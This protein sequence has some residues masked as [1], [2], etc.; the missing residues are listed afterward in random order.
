MT[1]VLAAGKREENSNTGVPWVRTESAGLRKTSLKIKPDE[2]II[3]TVVIFILRV[4]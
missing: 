2:W 3:H 4:V 1:Y